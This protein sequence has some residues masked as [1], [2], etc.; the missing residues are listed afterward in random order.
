[1]YKALHQADDLGAP[2]ELVGLARR[3][4]QRHVS[5]GRRRSSRGP[6]CVMSFD[7]VAGLRQRGMHARRLE[8]GLPKWEATGL[9]VASG[10]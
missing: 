5:L 9:L 4:E 3:E 7:A 2:V 8:D 10:P 1:M 6:W